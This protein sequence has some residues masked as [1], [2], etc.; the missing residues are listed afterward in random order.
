VKAMLEKT[1]K[2]PNTN[3]KHFFL[4]MCKK[5]M[6]YINNNK[7]TKTTTTTISFGFKK[8]NEKQTF[9]NKPKTK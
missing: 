8:K 9:S 3:Q 5:E 4:K 6:S 1:L 2:H 7:T